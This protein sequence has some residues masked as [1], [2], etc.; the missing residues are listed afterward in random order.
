MIAME[1]K[2][3]KKA[4]EEAAAEWEIFSICSVWVVADK[5]EVPNK[6]KKANLLVKKS[7]SL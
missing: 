2:G 3:L 4:A 1:C 7:K 6:P 5:E